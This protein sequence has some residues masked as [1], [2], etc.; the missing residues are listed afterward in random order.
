MKKRLPGFL[1]LFL[2]SCGS[3]W[4]QHTVSGRV[5]VPDGTALPGVSVLVK[6][7]N[8]GT[9]TDADG[10]FNIGVPDNN[11]TLVL[12]FIGY[13]SQEIAVGSQTNLNIRMTEDTQQLGEVVVTALGIERE[14]KSLSYAQQTVDGSTLTQARDINILNS[15]AGRA[16]GVDIRKSSSGPGGSTKVM[17]RGNKSMSGGS[18]PLFVID[19]IPMANN[20]GGQPNMWGG[21]DQ[22]DGMSQINPDDIESM[23]V[24]RGSN[25]AALYGSQGANG[26]VLITTKKG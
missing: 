4:A 2:I 13:T 7:T 14:A 22:G 19:G 21:T 6:G 9:S 17:L 18:Q 23:T 1:I 3:A 15:L 8:T 12:S 20:I 5:T 26:V 10:R 16:A 25:A 11:S 24:L